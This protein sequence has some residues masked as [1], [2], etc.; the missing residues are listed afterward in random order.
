MTLTLTETISA[1][2]ALPTEPDIIAGACQHILSPD[3]EPDHITLAQELC[4]YA[5]RRGTSIELILAA[6]ALACGGGWAAATKNDAQSIL[7]CK[8][9][10]VEAVSKAYVMTKGRELNELPP[11][12]AVE[13]M[14]Q[15]LKQARTMAQN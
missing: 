4:D 2:R 1:I 8:R 7:I 11:D 10:L 14:L 15:M 3:P 5:K 9:K 13:L 12:Q 6:L